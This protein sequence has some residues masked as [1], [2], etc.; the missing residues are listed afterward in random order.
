ML[1]LVLQ[2]GQILDGT[3]ADAFEAD[4]G[5][6]D[7]R[8]AAIGRL[9]D[10]ASD[11]TI[12]V[13]GLAVSPGFIDM[14]THSDFTLLA[15]GRAESQVHQGVTTEVVGQCGTSCAPVRSHDVIPVVSPWYKEGCHSHVWHSFGEYLEA[16][17]ATDLGVN[18]M[19]F[20]GHGTVHR[21]V[22]GDALRAGDADEVQEMCRIV[23]EAL[24]Q[25]AGG[26][27]TGLEYW[28]GIMAAPEHIVPMCEVTEKYGRL[29]AT[30]VRNR[31]TQY[32]LGF[33]ETIATA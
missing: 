18:V 28:P 5:V 25:G 33:A 13:A 21:A 17:E 24:E 2:N 12:D 26:F 31:D 8:I 3:G 19:A 9:S 23:E 22:L 27:S 16:L 14:H 11:Q 32:D 15:D 10:A 29:Y 20:V 6:K 1:D 7:G 30:H 4:I